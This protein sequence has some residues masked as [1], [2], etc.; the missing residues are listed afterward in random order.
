MIDVTFHYHYNVRVV[1]PFCLT[2]ISSSETEL[3][4]L[5]FGFS[6][7]TKLC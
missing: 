6:L 2:S 7:A 1:E 4:F 3:V 5:A